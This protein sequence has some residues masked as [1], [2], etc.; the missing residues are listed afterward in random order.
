MRPAQSTGPG[1]VTNRHM[2][3]RVP[4]TEMQKYNRCV[5]AFRF[6]FSSLG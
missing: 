1:Q 4:G 6:P 2:P 3:F 5:V